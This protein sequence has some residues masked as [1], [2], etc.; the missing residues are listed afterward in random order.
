MY[1]ARGP[2]RGRVRI[3]PTALDT[4]ISSM[5]RASEKAHV[6]MFLEFGDGLFLPLI[7]DSDI[8]MASRMLMMYNEQFHQIDDD[9][10][11]R[12]AH[13]MECKTQEHL[14]EESSES[15]GGELSDYDD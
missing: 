8:N 13:E 2:F 10:W 6:R 14:E 9:D 1:L 15:T 12:E 3:D 5:C 4:T 7:L 11:I